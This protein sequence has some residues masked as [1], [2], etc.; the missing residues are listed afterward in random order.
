MPSQCFGCVPPCLS[1]ATT[2]RS[3]EASRAPLAGRMTP[4]AP[5]PS[6]KAQ[7]FEPESHP[8]TCTICSVAIESEASWQRHITGKKHSK[9]VAKLKSE[10]AQTASAQP[11]HKQQ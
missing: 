11:P 5:S 9:A 6:R 4:A 7:K 3:R 2:Q 1:L 8:T 10:P